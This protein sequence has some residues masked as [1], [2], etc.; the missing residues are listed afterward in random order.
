[1]T[2]EGARASVRDRNMTH[3]LETALHERT[4]RPSL[5]DVL[6][7]AV[8]NAPRN[9][10]ALHEDL[11]ERARPHLLRSEVRAGFS[12]GHLLDVVLY[13]PL[14]LDLDDESGSALAEVLVGRLLGER[15]LDTWIGRVSAVATPARSS[16][17][18]LNSTD[19]KSETFPIRDLAEAV[20]AAIRGLYTSLPD[21]CW[22]A[23]GAEKWTLFEL[24]PEPADDYAAQDDLVLATTARPE[25]LKCFLQGARFCSERFSRH[26]ELF[27]YVKYESSVRSHEKRLAE[28]SRLEDRLSQELGGA[29]LGAVVGNGFGLKYSYVDLA[30]ARSAD[31][32][33]R[34][35]E[36]FARAKAGKRGWLLFCDAELEDRWVPL[37]RARTPPYGLPASEDAIQ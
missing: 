35:L 9:L 5:L 10:A 34:V 20:R 22:R 37:G 28:R 4:S 7:D 3:E 24:T 32:L 6:D 27:C 12:R 1:L 13:S 26:D 33:P 36:L 19:P 23:A 30:L 25:M 2:A 21:P 14:F 29:Q 31:A 16:L 18:V 8:R 11:E 15:L 17:R